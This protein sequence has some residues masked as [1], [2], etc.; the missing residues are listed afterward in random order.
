[1]AGGSLV[2]KLGKGFKEFLLQTNALADR[3]NSEQESDETRFAAQ[4]D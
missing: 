1:M 4:S 3:S 2:T